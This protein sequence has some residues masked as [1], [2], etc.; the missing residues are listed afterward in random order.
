METSKSDSLVSQ[1]RPS[2]FY[3]LRAEEGFEDH[4]SW[5]GSSTLLMSFRPHTQLEEADPVDEDAEDEGRE[6]RE[7][8]SR[9]FQHHLAS[10]P[11]KAR[12]EGQGEGQHPPH[13]QPSTMTWTCWMTMRLR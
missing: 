4:R 6:D 12:V 7:G 5:D 1:T 11:D 3:R 9:V 2:G 13:P 10:D 8:E